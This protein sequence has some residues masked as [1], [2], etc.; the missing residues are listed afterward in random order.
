MKNIKTKILILLIIAILVVYII[1]NISINKNIRVNNQENEIY[2]EKVIA[3]NLRI[4]IIYFDTINTILSTNT[5]IQNISRLIYE[6]LINLTQ[7]F[8]LEPCLATEWSKLDKTSYIIKLRENVK[9]QDGEIFDSED[10][11]FTYEFLKDNKIKSIYS[12]NISNIKEIKIIDDY[13]IKII[14]DESMSYFEYN[15]TFPIISSKYNN[16]YTEEKE[17]GLIGTGMYY[18]SSFED[19]S[20]TL[21]QNNNWWSKKEMK[22]DTINLNL[23][24]DIEV[25]LKNFKSSNVDMI[26]N[27]SENIYEYIENLQ[28][29][30][31]NYVGS[32]Y[33][34]ISF[35]CEDSI[36]QYKEIRQAINYSIDKEE[37]INNVYNNQYKTS[38][39]P[40]D[41]GFYLYSKNSKKVEYNL[42]NAK[43]ILENAGWTYNTKNWSKKIDGEN[44]IIELEILVDEDN[45]KRVKVAELIEEQ[46][47]KLG[48]NIEIK[49]VSENE[50]KNN[51]ERKE[52]SIAIINNTYGYSPSLDLYFEKNNISNYDGKNIINKMNQIEQE[53][54]EDKKRIL[55]NEIIDEYNTEVPYISLYYDTYTI[56]YSNN[57]IGEIEP[58]SYNVFYNIENWYREYDK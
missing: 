18:I 9:W 32:N 41:F 47:K 4:G 14:L 19:D 6:P 57:L 36:L 29:N 54:I 28:A 5:N 48:I 13:T 37:I 7:D 44:K 11:I 56:V 2:K 53:N 46:I 35:N 1:Y 8:K 40:L 52:Y 31:I 16:I 24:D 15:L 49:K 39:F 21:K 23:Y 17:N 3:T 27:H 38:N 33:D 20:I 45:Q 26:I 25:A 30:K 22:L 10:V 42:E 50:Y 34:Y 51:I 58:N 12:D 43:R 55:L